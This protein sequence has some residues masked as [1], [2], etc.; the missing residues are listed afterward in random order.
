MKSAS[1]AILGEYSPDFEPHTAT[2]AAIRHSATQLEVAFDVNWI[3]TD[4]IS[5]SLFANHSA[6]W[7]APG[8]PYKNL[9]KALWAI[10]F[11]RENNV[12]C[13]GT[14]GG[15]QH[16]ILEYAR[17][18]LGFKNAQHAEYDPYSSCLFISKLECSLAGREMLLQFVP[19][20]RVSQIYGSHSATEQYYCNFGINPDCIELLKS[21]PMNFV[22]SDAE[23]EIRVIELPQHPYYVG[24]LYVP[25]MRSTEQDPHPLV[26]AFLQS[27][28]EQ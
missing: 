10:R 1:I 15:F 7:V 6:I 26:T 11:A 17:N 8:S 4:D 14:C 22:A 12:P 24:T 25:Q 9:E 13:L 23:G 16:M 27:A 5:E 28:A 18:V 20:S 3:S 2:N 21:G 19:N